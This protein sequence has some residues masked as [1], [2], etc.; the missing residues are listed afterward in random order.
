[1]KATKQNQICYYTLK[2]AEILTVIFIKEKELTTLLFAAIVKE[3]KALE[4]SLHPPHLTTDK[5][6]TLLPASLIPICS[7][8]MN[9]AKLGRE[10]G[11]INF[12]LCDSFKPTVHQGQLCYSLQLNRKD[13]GKSRIRKENRFLSEMSYAVHVRKNLNCYAEQCLSHIC[14]VRGG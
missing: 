1:M 14:E 5:E 11:K 6:G 4:F 9:S 8:Q 7:Y 10:V 12:T 3:S 13:H 2:V